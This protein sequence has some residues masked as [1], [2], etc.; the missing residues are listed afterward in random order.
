MAQVNDLSGIRFGRWTA[1]RRVESDRHGV[2]YLCSCDCGKTGIINAADL[3]RGKSTSCGCLRDEKTK[4]RL[5]AQNSIHKRTHGASDSRLYSIWLGMKKRC[6]YP[7]T[8]GYANYGGR[9][10]QV[11]G[12]WMQSFEIFQT[13]ALSHGYREDLTIDRI[14]VDGNYCPDNCRWA[15]RSEQEHNKRRSTEGG[16]FVDQHR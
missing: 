16:V 9:G 3:K 12:E 15:T 7:K 5:P 13:W 10:I 14:N 1:L 6:N 4:A 8:N 2:F 11:C